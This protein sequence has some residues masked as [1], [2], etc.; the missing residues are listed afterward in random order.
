MEKNC[1]LNL[2]NEAITV[3]VKTRLKSKKAKLNQIIVKQD[4]SQLRLEPLGI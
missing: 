3:G 2:K 1:I 4:L